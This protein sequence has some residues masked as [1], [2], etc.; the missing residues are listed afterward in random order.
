MSSISH[1]EGEGLS[2]SSFRKTLDEE[3]R[4]LNVLCTVWRDILENDKDGRLDDTSKGDI[5]SVVGQAKLVMSER[6]QQFSGLV[7]NCE[8]NRGEK[9]TT[10]MDLRGF[11]EMIYFQVEDV[12][13]KFEALEK[14]KQSNWIQVE[15]K[16]NVKTA[17]TPTMV[18]TTIRKRSGQRHTASKATASSG[19]KAL[20]AAKRKKVP[21]N[22]ERLNIP[23][24]V[25][26]ES[27]E[28]SEAP[29]SPERTFN[30]GFFKI[31][32]PL[33]NLKQASPSR[34]TRSAGCFRSV[35]RTEVS[36]SAKRMSGLVSPFV[37]QLAR[38]SLNKIESVR[39]SSLFDQMD[40]IENETNKE[41]H[42]N[43]FWHFKKYC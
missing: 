36:E 13:Q 6:F 42:S 7:D 39:K 16:G 20:I 17:T 38:R 31:K 37:S 29:C 9:K 3:T 2:V 24:I 1:D 22:H 12:N 10:T 32:T 30:G 25:M 43:E 23:E 18:T 14:Q 28:T 33:P 15:K 35:R 4:R 8:L 40:E 41:N 19:L 21:T 34:L 11:W 26:N 5:R 27:E